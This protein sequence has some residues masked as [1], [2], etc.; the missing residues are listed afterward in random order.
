MSAADLLSLTLNVSAERIP[1]ARVAARR[2]RLPG[3]TVE[4]L[5]FGGIHVRRV[6]R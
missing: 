5:P 3:P 4:F 6:R 2:L 1:A